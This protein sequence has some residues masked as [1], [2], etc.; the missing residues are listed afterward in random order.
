MG[1][2]HTTEIGWVAFDENGKQLRMNESALANKS[3]IQ[4]REHRSKNLDIS[5]WT[6]DFGK[7][8]C[9]DDMAWG[10]SG[11][12]ATASSSIEEARRVFQERR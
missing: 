12:E 2:S 5:G 1:T 9:D 4:L 6:C 8:Q 7:L 11:E 10:L 3:A